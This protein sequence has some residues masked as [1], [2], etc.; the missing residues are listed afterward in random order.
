MN[1]Y[2]LGIEETFELL[3]RGKKGLS[4]ASAEEKL[5]LL[6]LNELSAGKKNGAWRICSLSSKM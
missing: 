5:S 3:G 2:R 4:S 1:W 6:G